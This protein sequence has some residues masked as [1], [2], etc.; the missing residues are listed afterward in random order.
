MG[1]RLDGARVSVMLTGGSD[2]RVT[3]A[4]L[5]DLGVVPQGEA[6]SVKR[7]ED[8]LCS[9]VFRGRFFRFPARKVLVAVS[10]LLII[11]GAPLALTLAFRSDSGM[12]WFSYWQYAPWLLLLS[13]L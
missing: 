2:V 4:V 11:N 3:Q 5:A 7:Y 10:D 13:A 1:L 8:V 9:S 12:S 6:P